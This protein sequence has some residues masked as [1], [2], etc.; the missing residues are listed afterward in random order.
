MASTVCNR[1]EKPVQS[2]SVFA[3]GMCFHTACFVCDICNQPFQDGLFYQN[4]GALL[5]ESDFNQMLGYNCGKC[6]Q[7]IDGECVNAL[8][9]KWHKECFVCAHCDTMLAGGFM[10]FDDKPYCRPCHDIIT[11]RD[12][13]AALDL[14]FRCKKR[15]DGIPFMYKG[16]KYHAYHFNC[17]LC[18]KELDLSCQEHDGKLY[19][20]QDYERATAPT[21]YSCKK[22]ILGPNIT[23]LGKAFH[24]E[25]FV[26]HKC[27]KSFEGGVFFEHEGKPF[28]EL[29]YHELTGVRCERCLCIITGNRCDK[30]MAGKSFGEWD[31]KPMCESCYLQLPLKVRKRLKDYA[32]E[33]KKQFRRE[34]RASKGAL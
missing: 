18:K 5:C 21:C 8:D 32:D 17:T 23:A 14:C 26:C 2:E 27:E 4:D 7:L 34:K 15:I 1:C 9:K 13:A 19:C 29:H 3:Q 6:K 16:S 12:H 20:P 11:E 31:D 10:R 25:H 24:P 22:I 33:D 30:D 28:C